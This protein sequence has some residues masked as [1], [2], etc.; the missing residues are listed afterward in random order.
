MYVCICD[1]NAPEWYVVGIRA[2]PKGG[3]CRAAA[4]AP[5]PQKLEVKKYKFCRYYVTGSFI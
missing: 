5:K 4:P 1:A 2:N 3:R